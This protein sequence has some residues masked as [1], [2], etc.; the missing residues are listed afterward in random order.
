MYGGGH[1]ER[2]SESDTTR[3]HSDEDDEDGDD[4]EGSFKSW[5]KQ[6]EESYQ[7]QLALALRISSHSASSAQSNYL[8]DFEPTS[9]HS[10]SDSPQSLSHRFWVITLSIS[11]TH[12]KIRVNTIEFLILLL[13]C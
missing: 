4:D 13:M 7:L 11:L 6:T 9:S 3:M 10:S 8:L 12:L 5:A 2:E 1:R